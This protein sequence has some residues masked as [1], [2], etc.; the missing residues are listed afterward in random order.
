MTAT[1]AGMIAASFAFV[2]LVARP[3]G[4]LLSD[5]MKS[6]KKTM[7]MYMAGIAVGFLGMSFIAKYGP[8]DADGAKTLLPMFEGVW[9][10]VVAVM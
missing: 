10:V 1:L 2:N 7:L 9:W 8:L 3:L 4:G 5:S 6:R